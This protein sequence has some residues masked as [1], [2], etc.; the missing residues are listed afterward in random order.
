MASAS[1]RD[2]QPV[3]RGKVVGWLSKVFELNPAGLNWPRGVLFLDM[4]LVPLV[5]FWAIGHEQYLLSALFGLLFAWLAD[6]GGGGPGGACPYVATGWWT[7]VRTEAEFLERWGRPKR[8]SPW[9]VPW[10]APVD[11]RW[12]SQRG[13]RCGTAT[14][15][16]RSS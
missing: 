4:A 6:P 13:C 16:R 7:A 1:A 14:P 11:T 2:E 8:R 15:V 9:F 3:H 12:S 5:V 10:P